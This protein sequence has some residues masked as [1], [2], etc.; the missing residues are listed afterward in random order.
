MR[1][2]VTGGLGFIGSA[3][4]RLLI[5]EGE[6]EILN[7]DKVTYAA[8]P[9]SVA[10]VSGS[11]RYRFVRADIADGP[12]MQRA[13]AEYR[14]DAVIHLAAE[15]HVD[16]SIDGPG[17][18]MVTNLVGTYELLEAARDYRR[19]LDS[20]KA[21]RFRFLHVSTD[22]VFGSLGKDDAPFNESTPYSPR[23]P[24]S[25][26]KAGSDHLVR[27]WHE[28][29][30]LPAIITNCSN[31]YGPYHFPEKLIP[32]TIVKALRGQEVGVYGT[33]ENIRDW[34]FVEDHARALLCVLERGVVGETYTIG[35]NA[36][37]RNLDVAQQI[38]DRLD[39][40]L[41]VS[42]DGPRRGLI[43]FVVDRPGHDFRYAIDF[44]KIQTELGWRPTRTFEQGLAQTVRWY[45]DNEPWWRAILDQR[46]A[47]D[48]LGTSTGKRP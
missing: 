45:L 12:A 13:F 23:S 36:Q 38:C 28:T 1:I 33:G 17:A 39:Q 22:E 40:E 18:F 4:V 46:Y 24:Y 37:R 7:L 32:L 29:Y 9:S 19:S 15:S 21:Q 5:G 31:N 6:H 3:V 16:R 43:R 35:G 8:S 25:A 11:P 48:R 20:V 41:G 27:A 34:L 44:S 26:S 14:P 2:I 30:G 10:G 47:G 42:Q